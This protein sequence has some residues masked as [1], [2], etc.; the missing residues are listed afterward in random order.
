MG[1]GP[2]C[3]HPRTARRLDRVGLVGGRAPEASR[4]AKRAVLQFLP[5]R[6]VHV[7]SLVLVVG[8]WLFMFGTMTNIF[9]FGLLTGVTLIFALLSDFLLAPAMLELVI[10][11]NYG[12]GLAEK[13]STQRSGPDRTDLG[14][15][16]GAASRA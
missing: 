16:V 10:R 15:P 9:Y 14:G 1:L 8:F 2:G 12:R 6:D 3:S 13:W 7:R 5:P 11:T 4:I